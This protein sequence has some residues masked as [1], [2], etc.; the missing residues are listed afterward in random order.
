MRGTEASV[1]DTLHYTTHSPACDPLV[2]PLQ[3]A[4]RFAILPNDC[5]FSIREVTM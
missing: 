3:A 4:T 2:R 5:Q 1:T